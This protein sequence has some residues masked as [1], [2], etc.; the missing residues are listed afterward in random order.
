MTG[1]DIRRLFEEEARRCGLLAWH[2][3]HPQGS[4]AGWPDTVIVYRAHPSLVPTL[5]LLEFKSSRER[6]RPEQVAWGEQLA[7]VARCSNGA[8]VY[9]VVRPADAHLLAGELGWR[10]LACRLGGLVGDATRPV[11]AGATS[12]EGN[13]AT[14]SPAAELRARQALEERGRRAGVGDEWLRAPDTAL[15]RVVEAAEGS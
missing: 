8:V 3:N 4:P 1:E 13:G 14:P 11:G 9:R 2:D 10:D 6:L 7:E 12:P 15:R 5:L